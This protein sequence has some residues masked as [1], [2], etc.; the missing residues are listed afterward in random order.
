M[1]RLS[2]RERDRGGEREDGYENFL[3]KTGKRYTR[4]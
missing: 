3:L 4:G 1:A 2:K